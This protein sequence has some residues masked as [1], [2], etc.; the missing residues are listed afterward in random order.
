MSSGE[1]QKPVGVRRLVYRELLA[2]D[3]RKMA[4]KSNDAP[5]GG[6]ARDLRF[7]FK[8][9]DGVFA[10]LLPDTR[11]EERR[12]E[13]VKVP[14]TLRT[15]LV[16]VDED[17]AEMVWETPTDSRGSEGRIAKVHA[18]PAASLLLQAQEALQSEN[19]TL[20][21]VFVLLVQDDE[22]QLRVHYAY[23]EDMRAGR[24]AQ[25]VARRVLT[26]YDD[27]NRR[28]D[29]AVQGYIDFTTNF[30]YPHGVR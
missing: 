20:P 3:W 7:P 24:W 11:V 21:E 16:H 13:G 26:H 1:L 25:A 18:S 10:H 30:H 28:R 23:V 14:M 15:G 27:P 12:R 4:A 22:G 2:G 17:T 29:R 9:F 8:A 5:T 19:G 6:G